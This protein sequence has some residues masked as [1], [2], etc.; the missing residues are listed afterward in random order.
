[1][2]WMWYNKCGSFVEPPLIRR[3]RHLSADFLFLGFIVFRQ[4]LDQRFGQQPDAGVEHRVHAV[5]MGNLRQRHV[6]S[7]GLPRLDDRLFHQV[8]RRVLDHRDQLFDAVAR[9]LAFHALSISETLLR[10]PGL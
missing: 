4:L 10:V 1:M 9:I 6:G 3:Q 5:L 8:K 2:G 7:V